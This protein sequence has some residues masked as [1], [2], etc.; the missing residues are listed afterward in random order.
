MDGV[1]AALLAMMSTTPDIGHQEL[2]KIDKTCQCR[3][4]NGNDL[5]LP[6]CRWTPL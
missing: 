3:N 6:A 2:N 1:N 4:A 5:R